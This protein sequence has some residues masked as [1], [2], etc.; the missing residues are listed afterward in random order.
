MLARCGD[1]TDAMNDNAVL[2]DEHK[3]VTF[4]V[5]PDYEG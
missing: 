5:A 2:F 1:D 3:I 4:G